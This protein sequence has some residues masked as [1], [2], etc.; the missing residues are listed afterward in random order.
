MPDI[1][2]LSA[3]RMILIILLLCFS[4]SALALDCVEKGTGIVDKPA[5]PVGQLAIP[6]N[7]PVGTKI[8]ES[9]D[10]NVTAYCDNV[11]GSIIDVVH[12]YFNPKSQSIGEG[13]LLGVSYNGQDLEQNEQRLSTNSTPI[14]K[15]Q[16]VTVNVTFRLYIKVS[17]NAPSSGHYQGADQFTVFQLD[18]SRGINKSPGA[19]NLKY[20]LS[21]LQGIRFL[22]CGSD[23]KVY[24]ESQIVDFGPIQS[25]ILSRSSG[26][27]LPFAIKAVKQ[28]CLDN[29]SL[30]AEFSTA[31]PLLDNTA[32]DLSNGA[33]LMLYNDKEQAITFNRYDDFAELNNVNEVTKNFTA[34]VSAIPG[35]ALSLGQFDASV[36]V[37]INYY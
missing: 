26:I 12:F 14:K 27:S 16:N 20:N 5:I 25:T 2:R 17:G 36:I 18:G 30:Q 15:G 23:L 32:I 19:K 33:K 4:R 1:Y 34:K 28:G 13:L 37:K 9:N 8:W 31:S 24:P 11:L 10:I 22:A 29:F 6:S 7:V 3:G 21:G 35:R